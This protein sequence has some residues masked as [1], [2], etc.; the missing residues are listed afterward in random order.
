[1][2]VI[3]HWP[4]LEKTKARRDELLS[5]NFSPRKR[6]KA[7]NSFWEIFRNF[8]NANF[9]DG[10]HGD[11]YAQIWSCHLRNSKTDNWITTAL[12]HLFHLLLALYS[13]PW[14]KTSGAC[15]L[16]P[17]SSGVILPLCSTSHP[18]K[19]FSFYFSYWLVRQ[20]LVSANRYSTCSIKC[21]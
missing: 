3:W 20:P 12:K 10:H 7:Q 4:H 18:L 13:C 11:L 5:W 6:C 17:A 1:M 16:T 8:E 9:Y 19:L 15:N 2:L 21:L 14:K